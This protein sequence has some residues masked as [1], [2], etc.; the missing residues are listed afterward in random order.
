MM[1]RA[2]TGARDTSMVNT[3]MDKRKRLTLQVT[4]VILYIKL[5]MATGAIQTLFDEFIISNTQVKL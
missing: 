1:I 2:S 4:F 3:N 5:K